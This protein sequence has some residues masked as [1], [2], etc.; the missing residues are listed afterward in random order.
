M[1]YMSDHRGCDKTVGYFEYM[2]PM[3]WKGKFGKFKNTFDIPAS[4]EELTQALT[5]GKG[6]SEEN[7]NEILALESAFRL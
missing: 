4:R 7:V 6:Y 3:K 2:N 1:E 5:S